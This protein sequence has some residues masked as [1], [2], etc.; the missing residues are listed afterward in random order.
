MNPLKN[1]ALIIERSQYTQY[2]PGFYQQWVNH[3]NT[4]RDEYAK[5]THADARVLNLLY[6]LHN[7]SVFEGGL[8]IMT[9]LALLKMI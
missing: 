9:P 1:L 5:I 7:Q 6:F 8:L 4:E 2:S 3:Q